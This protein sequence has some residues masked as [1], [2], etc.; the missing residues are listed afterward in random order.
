MTFD[1]GKP[2]GKYQDF[3]TGFVISD[4]DVWGRP[5]GVSVAKD[6]SLIVTEDGS[7]TIWRISHET[8]PS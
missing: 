5:V 2:T 3:A 6:G 1:D 8:G 7:G 4:G